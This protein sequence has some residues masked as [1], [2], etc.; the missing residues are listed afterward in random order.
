MLSRFVKIIPAIDILNSN[1]VRLTKGDYDSV[2]I[3][4]HDP[5]KVAKNF[6]EQG[7]KYLHI[8]DLDGARDGK[9]VNH[10]AIAAII[11]AANLKVQIGGG[12]RRLEDAENLFKIGVSKIII[13]SM[14]I[15]DPNFFKKLINKYGKDKIIAG[16]DAK[17]NM[18]AISGW[19]KTTKNTYES[20]IQKAIDLGTQEFIV[21]D[22][23]KDGMLKGPNLEMYKNIK[24]KFP[25][26]KIIASGG[27]SCQNDI[28]KLKKI[29]VAGV[30]VGKAIYEGKIKLL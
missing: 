20:L 26:I 15:R 17:N 25:K 29:K 11:K 27:V 2:K 28:N 4:S 8:V 21:T 14:L 19:V 13:G 22:I 9:P 10:G 6:Q 24:A 5:V 23:D 12:I 1:C 3:Y 30:I 7:I 18:A 16:I